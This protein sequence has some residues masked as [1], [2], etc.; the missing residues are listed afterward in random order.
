MGCVVIFIYVNESLIV[1][2]MFLGYFFFIENNLYGYVSID[3]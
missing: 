1:I 2:N 3:L